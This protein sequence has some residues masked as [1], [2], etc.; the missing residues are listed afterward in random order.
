MLIFGHPG[1]TLGAAVLLNSALTRSYSRRLRKNETGQHPQPSAEA[2]PAQNY[3]SSSSASWLASWRDRIDIR[4]LFAGSL[5]PDIIDKPVGQYFFRVIFSNSRIFGH[6]LLFLILISLVG[7]YL[8]RNRRKTW[9]LALSFGSLS[10]LIEDQI[11][12]MPQTLLWPLFGFAF[13]RT[14][15]DLDFLIYWTQ[16]ILYVLRTY[17]SVYVPEII[18]ALILIWFTVVLVRRNKVRIFLTRGQV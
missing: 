12:R 10:H 18:G 3:S 7:F 14:A 4:L 13:P 2:P 9:L 5:L 17:P 15:P 1:I 8:Y 16:N 6:T 11:W